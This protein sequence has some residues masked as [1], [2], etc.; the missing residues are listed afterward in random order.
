M[1]S[2][3]SSKEMPSVNQ[4]PS[5]PFNILII[6]EDFVTGKRAKN[7]LDYLAEELGDEFEFR[8]SM[9]R[10]GIL[11]NS[12]LNILAAPALA[13]ADLLIISLRSE[14]QIPAKIRMLIDAWLAEKGT[15]DCALVAL[16][17]AEAASPHSSVYACLA[18]LARLHG[19]DLLEQTLNDTE[20]Q[21][22]KLLKLVWVF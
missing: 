9:W 3:L 20:S 2:R 11:Q 19:L 6:Y 18:N 21:E 7:G 8:H 14:G 16:F 22:E 1:H 17:E 13:E 15:R 4:R 12:K 10:L 5:T